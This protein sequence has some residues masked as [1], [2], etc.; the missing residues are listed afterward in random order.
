M[1]LKHAWLA[2]PLL[3]ACASGVDWSKPGATQAALDADVK[4]CRLAA[5]R[6]PALP[7][8]RTAPPSGTGSSTTGSDLD[9]DT[10][11]AQAQRIESCMRS[12]GYQLVS[13]SS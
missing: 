1:D 5:Q 10:Q 8:L 9:A 3:A 2:L 13:K 7:R 6:V 11:L 4:D 12:R